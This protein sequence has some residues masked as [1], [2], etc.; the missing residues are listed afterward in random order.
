M[1]G[2]PAL[3]RAGAILFTSPFQVVIAGLLMSATTTTER[4]CADDLSSL[5]E[6][7]RE[8][9]A[10]ARGLSRPSWFSEDV[11]GACRNSH[12]RIN[13]SLARERFLDPELR[14]VHSLADRVAV[15]R[16]WLEEDLFLL[17]RAV[18]DNGNELYRYWV[19]AAKRGNEWYRR[20]LEYRLKPLFKLPNRQFFNPVHD[21]IA[22]TQVLFITLTF[23][24]NLT[25]YDGA[26][27]EISHDYN[28]WATRMRQ[29]YGSIC[30]VRVFEATERGYA[31]VH[32][33]AIFED[34]EFTCKR[35]RERSEG[36]YVYRVDEKAEI[37]ELW[38]S[39]VDVQACPSV[40]GAIRYLTKYLMKQHGAE[41]DGPYA[42]PI[43][44]NTAYYSLTQMWIHKRRSF[45]ISVGTRQALVDLIG[46]CA[47]QTDQ[48][49]ILGFL[50]I[51]L[52][53][54]AICTLEQAIA[55][56]FDPSIGF[57]PWPSPSIPGSQSLPGLIPGHVVRSMVQDRGV[58]R[59]PMRC[60][61]LRGECTDRCALACPLA[62]AAICPRGLSV[63]DRMHL[64]DR[65]VPQPRWAPVVRACEDPQ[66]KC[67][68]Q[69]KIDTF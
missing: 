46:P 68:G 37:A 5:S 45:S 54:V 60:D 64:E 12:S 2:E 63:L 22:T 15:Y 67:D 50:G 41:V 36:R 27:A 56:G 24:T 39:F 35:S 49:L 26:W 57:V 62:G 21:V 8:H 47:T 7:V 16:A 4:S 58:V 42:W 17:L 1:I 10:Q 30:F 43:D 55:L 25:D 66:P 29:L 28:R 11:V 6:F 9:A 52:E 38:H 53:L 19:P 23:N 65:P 31:H 14:H 40:H 59:A 51:R 18:D 20:R 61:H 69:R 44:E 13:L 33:L 32:V 34:H 48:A 3:S